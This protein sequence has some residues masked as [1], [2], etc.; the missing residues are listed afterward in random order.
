MNPKVSEQKRYLVVIPARGGSKRLPGKNL[1]KI[2]EY[3]LIGSA[4]NSVRHLNAVDEIC[5][6]TD[7]QKIADEAIKYGPYVHFMRPDHL[8]SDQAKTFDVVQHAI[9]WFLSQ[10][11]RFGS[12]IVLQPTSPLRQERHIQEAIQL[13]EQ[14]NAQA[15]VSVCKLE[16]PLEWCAELGVD[17]TM[18]KFG[19]NL[20]A[21]KRSQELGEKFRLN[22]AI[23]IYD[24]EK[25]LESNGFFYNEKTY[26][27]EMDMISSV[28]VDTYD[29]FLLA[30]YWG[31]LKSRN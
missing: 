25:V 19:L 23:Y 26:A 24:I 11:V 21:R 12:V 9:L 30:T 3:S 8:A 29:D 18:E 15:V 4:I 10:G 28:D 2:G 16:H 14:W 7:D 1:M 31:S 22:G 6:T 13:Y 27:Y 20:D 17:G 5:I